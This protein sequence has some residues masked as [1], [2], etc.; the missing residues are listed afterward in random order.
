MTLL[1]ATKGSHAQTRELETATPVVCQY[2]K[3]PAAEPEPIAT[4]QSG[5]FRPGA[6]G[7]QPPLLTKHEQL[8][9]HIGQ[10]IAVRGIVSNSKIATIIGVDVKPGDLR[11]EDCYAVGILTKWTTTQEQLDE[12]F[13][14][15]GPVATRGPG[16]TYKLCFDLSGK[17]AEARRWP[18]GSDIKAR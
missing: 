17:A 5:E 11:G 16:T 2:G 15:H 14:K 8:N 1:V 4:K 9:E 13:E 12:L 7:L 6:L 18:S 3:A 10:L